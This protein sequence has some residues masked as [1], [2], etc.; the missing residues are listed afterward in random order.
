MCASAPNSLAR[1]LHEVNTKETQ[2]PRTTTNIASNKPGMYLC[3]VFKIYRIHLTTVRV[4][5]SKAQDKLFNV[6]EVKLK[7]VL[8][9]RNIAILLSATAL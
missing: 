5:L 3:I 2:H 9:E 8:R 4:L 1:S 6:I 7:P